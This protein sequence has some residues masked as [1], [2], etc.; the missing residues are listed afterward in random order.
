MAE[1]SEARRVDQQFA[2]LNER[3]ASI[4]IWQKFYGEALM[5]IGDEILAKMT[6][7]KADIQK[8]MAA[9]AGAIN[10]EQAALISSG[11]DEMRALFAAQPPAVPP[12]DDNP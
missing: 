10:N 5:A 4:E 1:Y 6:A 2:L 7:L 8:V 9:N 11:I 3:L 12:A